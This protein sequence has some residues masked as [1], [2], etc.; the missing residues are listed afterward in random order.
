MVFWLVARPDV[1]CRFAQQLTLEDL[2]NGVVEYVH[3][4]I[5]DLPG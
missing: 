1:Q 2:L 3:N 4:T 5:G